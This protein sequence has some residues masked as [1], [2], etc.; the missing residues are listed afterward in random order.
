MYI[1][2]NQFTFL[3]FLHGTLDI[4]CILCIYVATHL[5]NFPQDDLQALH[6]AVIAKK[7]EVIKYLVE[8]LNVPIN[9]TTA[10]V[11]NYSAF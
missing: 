7:I 2:G 9:I 1:C 3:K 5:N 11:S 4:F 6:L 8:T 10:V